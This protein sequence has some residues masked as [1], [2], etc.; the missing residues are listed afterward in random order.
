MPA[1]RPAPPAAVEPADPQQVLRDARAKFVAA[2][3]AEIAYLADL[4]TRA[5][6]RDAVAAAN[7]QRVVHRLAGFEVLADLRRL[8]HRPR[9][10]VLCAREH[11]E[12]VA[13]AFELGADDYLAKPFSPQELRARISRLLR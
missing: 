6:G 8:E 4:V 13:R 1:E 3:S 11:D 5:A 7:L 9:V 12:D 10:V 2:F